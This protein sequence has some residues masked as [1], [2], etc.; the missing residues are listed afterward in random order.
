MYEFA[1]N[2]GVL[3]ELTPGRWAGERRE[4]RGLLRE[5]ESIRAATLRGRARAC[6]A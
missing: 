4:R 5:R 3:P 1:Q 6:R 2:M